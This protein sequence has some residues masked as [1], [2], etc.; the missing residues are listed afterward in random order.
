[1]AYLVFEFALLMLS[2][3][4]LLFIDTP[5][6]NLLLI[7]LTLRPQ[8]TIGLLCNL[9]Q[10][11]LLTFLKLCVL[12]SLLPVPPPCLV[13]PH[14]RRGIPA[15]SKPFIHKLHP[16]CH[17]SL[18]YLAR[19]SVSSRKL[20]GPPYNTTISTFKRHFARYSKRHALTSTLVVSPPFFLA[21]SR[22]SL[23]PLLRLVLSFLLLPPSR[24]L[25]V[26]LSMF[27]CTLT[28]S[29]Y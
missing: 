8:L 14:L 6:Y 4:L 21:L 19:I 12:F 15:H 5:L 1:M 9:A 20:N 25:T 10:T 28:K 23:T 17:T 11:F 2:L 16:N 27:I 3:F 7:I 24:V 26:S 29:F 18:N 13:F 22:L